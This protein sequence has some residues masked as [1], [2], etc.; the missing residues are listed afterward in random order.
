MTIGSFPF[1]YLGVPLHSRKLFYTECKPLIAKVV[2]R[3]KT[4]TVRKLSYADRAQLIRSVLQ[5]IQAYWCQIFLLPK[6]VLREIQTTLRS[7]LWTGMDTNSRKSPISWDYMCNKKVCGG[8]NFKEII[9]WNKAAIA[10]HFW[11]LALK[12]DRL[13]IKWLH[14]YYIKQADVWTAAI[15]NRLSWAIK[16][17]LEARHLLI[18]LTTCN[19]FVYHNKFSIRKC[20][21][22]LRGEQPKV[23]W[24]RITCNSKASP[25]AIF[26]TWMMLHG[27]LNIKTR[28]YQWGVVKDKHCPICNTADETLEHL[29]FTCDYSK[30]IWSRCLQLINVNITSDLATIISTVA[31]HSRKKHRHHQLLNMLF[32]ECVYHIWI[33]RNRKV[34]DDQFLPPLQVIRQIVFA[35]ACR[36]DCDVTQLIL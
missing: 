29:F 3:V 14:V 4:W 23:E 35:V 7:F 19:Q 5:G 22:F 24:R 32:I 16:K 11:A 1:R 12:Q 20:Y 9:T 34:F 33:Q 13:W 26:I 15:P 27:R 2:A 25:K 31:K 30:A 36:C 18:D 17:I 21:W 8:L 28:L 6:K 10:K